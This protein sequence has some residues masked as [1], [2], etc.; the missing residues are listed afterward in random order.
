MADRNTISQLSKS[1]SRTLETLSQTEARSTENTHVELESLREK[2]SA[3]IDDNLQNAKARL[4]SRIDELLLKLDLDIDSARSTMKSSLEMRDKSLISL[5]YTEKVHINQA[6]LI[7]RMLYSLEIRTVYNIFIALMI[8]LA[9]VAL[10]LDFINEKDFYQGWS[11]LFD[12]FGNWGMVVQGLVVLWGMSLLPVL[13]L[14]L[15]RKGVK[16]AVVVGIHVGYVAFYSNFAWRYVLDKDL[17]VASSF[18]ILS[19]AARLGMKMHS[20]IRE[21]LLYGVPN[22][23]SCFFGQQ[24]SQKPQIQIHDLQSEFRLYTYFSFAPTLIYRDKYPI[25]PRQIR[26]SH[27]SVHVFNFLASILFTAIMFKCHTVPHFTSIDMNSLKSTTIA[28]AFISSV[29]PGMMVFLNIFFGVIHSFQSLFSELLCFAD[30]RFYSDWWNAQGPEDLYKGLCVPLYEWFATYIYMDFQRFSKGFIPSSISS[31]ITGIS[32]GLLSE[33]VIDT[34]LRINFPLM[35]LIFTV[36]LTVLSIH[37][38]KKWTRISNVVLWIALLLAIGMITSLYFLEYQ[39]QKQGLE[40]ERGKY[41]PW[42]G[43]L[44]L[45][46]P[47]ITLV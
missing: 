34:S 12:S 19:E 18:V 15:Q 1:I 40:D 3:L 4:S 44:P 42:G 2:L 29:L 8:N 27:V 9:I 28:V 23:F 35:F 45:W 37:P 30:R 25:L 6:A 32:A 38:V 14:Q 36:P 39:A 17:P 22:D 33:A 24:P 16:T 46:V 11:V 20:Y 31:L 26:F 21:K 10:V 47:K 41:G 13:Y 43:F 5:P 7:S